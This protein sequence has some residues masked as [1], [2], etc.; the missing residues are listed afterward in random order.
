M[1]E[2]SNLRSNLRIRDHPVQWVALCGAP[3]VFTFFS[4]L[5]L[6]FFCFRCVLL[7]SSGCSLRSLGPS[8]YATTAVS[9]HVSMWTY[10]ALCDFLAFFQLFV[11]VHP[12]CNSTVRA[13]Q[14]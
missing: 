3:T 13:K 11:Q 8:Q 9:G 2:A 1:E 7:S 4:F 12:G 6:F 14:C 10:D 5:F